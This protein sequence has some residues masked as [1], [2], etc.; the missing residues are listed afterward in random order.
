MKIAIA[1]AQ[2]P[3]ISGGAEFMTAELV[4]VLR[5]FGHNTEVVSLPFRFGPHSEVKRNMNAWSSESFDKFD[6]GHIDKVIC[7][8]FPSFYLNHP[9]KRVWLM[10]QH[11]S[12][13]ELFDSPYGETSSNPDAI[14]L[15]DEIVER[16]TTALNEAK[17]I[18]T[19]SKRV[20]ERMAHYNGVNSR[21]LYQPSRLTE[22]LKIGEQLPYIFFPSRLETLKRQD[23]LIQAA[24]HLSSPCSIIIAGEG[25]QGTNLEILVDKLGLSNRV[26][27][28][29]RIDDNE[30]IRWYSNALGVFFGPF[31]E[32]YGFITLEAMKSSK[33]VITCKDSGGPTEFVVDRETGYISDP[34]PVA[35][36]QAIDELYFNRSKAKQ[37]GQTAHEH[38]E[39]LDIS[40]KNVV[41]NLLSDDIV[42][43]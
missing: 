24:K 5:E 27:F 2:V 15:R 6:C 19:I 30:L 26:R 35:V 42:G 8:K 25:G 4:R 17:A 36:A 14:A 3:F 10:H 34:D 41:E 13:Y 31:E 39:S 12:V 37:M 7:L 32:D 9:N 16:D 18:F 28:L 40:W 22:K 11:R 23:L 43:V 29:G 33:P 1:T 21:H 20:S 38:Y